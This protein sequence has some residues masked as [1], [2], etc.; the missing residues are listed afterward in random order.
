MEPLS[1]IDTHCHLDMEHYQDDFAEILSRARHAHINHI[2]SIGIDYSSSEKAI[3][4]AKS[5]PFISATVG[6]HPHDIEELD[7]AMYYR[8]ESLITTNRDHIVGYGEIGLDY[9]KNY[10]DIS[11]QK[12]HFAKQIEL[13]QH[14]NLPLIIHDRDAHDDILTILKQHGPYAAGGVLHCFSG[15]MDFAQQVLNLGF[16]ISIPGIVTF[17]NAKELQQVAKD[18]PLDRM[19][20]ETDGPFLAPTPYRGKRNEPSYIPLIAEKIAELR[21][22]S[23]SEVAMATSSNAQNLF[24]LAQ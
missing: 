11:L 15:D 14:F 19:L 16:Y 4:L 3:E 7:D 21:N 20:L 22:I 10:A 24:Q 23:V 9:F 17:K 5:H 2:L 18:I 1:F 8:L 12:I 6:V 13:A